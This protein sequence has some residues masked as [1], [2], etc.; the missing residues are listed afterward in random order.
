MEPQKLTPKRNLQCTPKHKPRKQ[1][2]CGCRFRLISGNAPQMTEATWQF[3]SNYKSNVQSPPQY[4][5]WQLA[6]HLKLQNAPQ[7]TLPTALRTRRWNKDPEREH[8]ERDSPNRV[9]GKNLK[10]AKLKPTLILDEPRFKMPKQTK[11]TDWTAHQDFYK[12]RFTGM[13]QGRT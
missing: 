2:L 1:I 7:I 9:N 10:P 13:Q 12:T 3:T 8:W 4:T 6:T 11:M 5:T